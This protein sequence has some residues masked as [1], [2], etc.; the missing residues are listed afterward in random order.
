M[1]IIYV[2]KQ[3]CVPDGSK[4]AQDFEIVKNEPDQYVYASRNWSKNISNGHPVL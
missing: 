1:F 3:K 4:G 2:K